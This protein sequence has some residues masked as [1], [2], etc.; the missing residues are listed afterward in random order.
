[1][2]WILRLGAILCLVPFTASAPVQTGLKL[3]SRRD[4]TVAEDPSPREKVLL[5][6]KK[7]GD[8]QRNLQVLEGTFDS[9]KRSSPLNGEDDIAEA[10]EQ[11]VGIRLGKIDEND[12]GDPFGKISG[13]ID[14]DGQ[15]AMFG[16]ELM[17]QG[18]AHYK[19]DNG[20]LG[21]AQD[22]LTSDER[23]LLH[24]LKEKQEGKSR[25]DVLRQ[26]LEARVS[27]REVGEANGISQDPQQVKGVPLSAE[28]AELERGDQSERDVLINPEPRHSG[29]TSNGYFVNHPFAESELGPVKAQLADI[30]EK[31][32]SDLKD[33]M[34]HGVSLHD[35]VN[36]I[37]EKEKVSL[38]R[39]ALL[40]AEQLADAQREIE[41]LQLNA[42]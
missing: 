12:D 41:K 27:D 13:N 18:N 36:D 10:L 7:L 1:M 29:I 33:A 11:A 6:Q 34:D 24:M 2:E 31:L 28:I 30:E 42:E 4:V 21:D 3:Q 17:A 38:Q 8:L 23:E 37:S 5:L 32:F 16:Q 19:V 15:Q 25:E 14:S 22:G 9:E 20:A 40:L 39:E 35:L 26:F